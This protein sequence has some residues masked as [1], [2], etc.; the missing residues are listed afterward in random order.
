MSHTC[1]TPRHSRN[2]QRFSLSIQTATKPSASSNHVHYRSGKK[3]A[4][5]LQG[6]AQISPEHEEFWCVVRLWLPVSTRCVFAITE[7]RATKSITDGRRERETETG[8]PNNTQGW[9]EPSTLDNNVF[10]SR[11]VCLASKTETVRW[12]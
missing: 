7:I 3:N 5:K 11:N 6:P 2:L 4:R 10:D 8:S 1:K 12:S 9:L